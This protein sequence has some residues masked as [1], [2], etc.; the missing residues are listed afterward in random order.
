MT[1]IIMGHAFD[2]AQAH[3]QHGL[4]T[5][6]GLDLAFFIDR[7]HQ[8]MIGRV[9][10]QA[11]YVAYLLD[12]EGIGGKFETPSS[13]GLQAEGLKQAMHGGTGDAAGLGGL[14]NA[15]VR[16]RSWFAGERAFQ[17]RRNL[18][19]VDAVGTAGRQLVVEPG[20]AMP[21]ESLPPL[22]DRGIRPAQTAG[23]LGIAL[24]CRRPEYE[25]GTCDQGRWQGAGS[26]KTAKLSL[27]VRTQS[28]GGLGASRDH[29][30]SLSQGPSNEQETSGCGSTQ[31]LL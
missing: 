10:V 7:E 3:G 17:Q 15:P 22:A 14:S 12:E 21:N 9:Q 19:I 13:V 28:E 8:R 25:F 1:N 2:V 29:A 31:P 30:R 26:G 24:P 11:D 18:L 20:Q 5:V 23:D 16:A 4:G 27:L 6:Q